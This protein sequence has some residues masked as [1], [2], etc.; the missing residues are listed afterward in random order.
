[1]VTGSV[2]ECIHHNQPVDFCVRVHLKT[3]FW[4]DALR[5]THLKLNGNKFDLLLFKILYMFEIINS[6]Y[7]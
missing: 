7:H 2:T 1:M 4:R 5:Q 3:G 6:W